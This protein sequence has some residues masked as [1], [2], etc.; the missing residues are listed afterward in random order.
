VAASTGGPALSD[1]IRDDY[2]SCTAADG[3]PVIATGAGS[4]A[5][6]AP[7]LRAVN[8]TGFAANIDELAVEHFG[9][10]GLL[11]TY[12]GDAELLAALPRLPGGLAGAVHADAVDPARVA[13][14][15]RR[16]VWAPDHERL[17]IRRGRVRRPMAGHDGCPLR[18]GSGPRP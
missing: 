13:A 9:P 15:L 5:V 8:L 4:D 3:Q 10:A 12:R 1:R 14:V 11:I 18:I 7:E 17:A 6:L 2:R 16:R